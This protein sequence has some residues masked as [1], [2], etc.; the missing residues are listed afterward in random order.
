MR[1]HVCAGEVFTFRC[2]L[3]VAA[4]HCIQ[5]RCG[6]ATSFVTMATGTAALR[7]L[8]QLSHRKAV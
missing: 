3:F 2:E 4:I 8:E 7:I 6:Y 5:R 1:V